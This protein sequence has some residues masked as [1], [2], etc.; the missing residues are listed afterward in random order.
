MASQWEKQKAKRAELCRQSE[1]DDVSCKNCKFFKKQTKSSFYCLSHS[2]YVRS[3]DVCNTFDEKQKPALKPTIT[4]VLAQARK[5][6]NFRQSYLS[7]LKAGA[8]RV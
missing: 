3:I 1:N 8:Y 2:I 4:E 5:T 7:A 6:S